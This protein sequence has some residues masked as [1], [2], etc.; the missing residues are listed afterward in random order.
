MMEKGKKKQTCLR[1]LG[2][3]RAVLASQTLIL[4]CTVLTYTPCPCRKAANF[5]NAPI[6]GN[7]AGAVLFLVS[8]K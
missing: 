6:G 2:E 3:K 5:V 1:V 4:R 7:L 8:G